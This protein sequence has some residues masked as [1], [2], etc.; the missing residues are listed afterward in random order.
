M[1]T[2]ELKKNIKVWCGWKSR[3]LYYTGI[4]INGEYKFVDINDAITMITEKDLEHLKKV[5]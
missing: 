5:Q 4:V 3:F 1:K 2:N